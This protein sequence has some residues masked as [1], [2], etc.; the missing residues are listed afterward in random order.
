MS[1]PP[2]KHPTHPNAP[3]YYSHLTEPDD[4]TDPERRKDAEWRSSKSLRIS[5]IAL[6]LAWKDWFPEKSKLNVKNKEDLATVEQVRK[7]L[8]YRMYRNHINIKTP[9]TIPEYINDENR[10]VTKTKRDPDAQQHIHQTKKPKHE[11]RTPLK[12]LST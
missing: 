12:K 5:Q 7:E 8:D 2:P 11:K 3:F 10:P 1:H 6:A 4:F 9:T